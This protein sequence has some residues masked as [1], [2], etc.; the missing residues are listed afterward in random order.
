DDGTFGPEV[1]PRIRA[2]ASDLAKR[3]NGKELILGGDRLK[4]AARESLLTGNACL[5]M[6]IDKEG[7]SRNDWGISK[8]A[9]R[10]SLSVFVDEED[11]GFLNGYW[12]RSQSYPSDSDAFLHPLTT[13]W[14]SWEK[15]N[16][17]GE[18]LVLPSVPIW[19]N[20]LDM[21]EWVQKA[22]TDTAVSPWLHIMPEGFGQD[23]KDSYQQEYQ[24][25]QREGAVTNLFL[26]SG[27]EVKKA[28]S[29][30]AT[31]E[32]LIDQWLNL[33]YQMVPPGVPL[34]LYPG[35]GMEASTG[36]ELANQPAMAYGR[37]VANVRSMLGEQIRWALS[38]EI[39]LKEGYEFLQEN[40]RYDITWPKWEVLPVTDNQSSLVDTGGQPQSPGNVD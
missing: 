20:L 8:T 23:R 28:A 6:A 35:L 16:S 13:L 14:F 7:I 30:N 33:R 31:L 4:R 38:L 15:H 18:P 32:P 11:D 12:Q 34:W 22:A 27:A 39:L 26:Y 17:Y 37:L 19:M 36:K 40:N 1:H 3:Y 5:A 21:S 2:I 24:Q 9:Y 25:L 10:P 29:G